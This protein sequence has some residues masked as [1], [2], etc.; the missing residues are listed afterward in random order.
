MLFKIYKKEMKDSFRDKR[1]LL[2][3]VFLPILM[4]TALTFFY[5]SLIAG[6]EDETYTL[7]VETSISSTQEMILA[8]MENV[9]LL[10]ADHPE[11]VLEEGNAHAAIY[12]ASDFDENIQAGE[13]G[14]VEIV[15]DTFSDKSATLMHLVQSRL[16]GFEQMIVIDRLQQANVDPAIT[17]AI[18]VEQR[19]MN[20]ENS[21]TM[22]LAFL[23][24]VILSIAIGVGA[25]PS[26]A[27]LFA[28]EKEKKTMEALLMTPVHRSTLLLAKYL[29]ISSVGVII[30]F[31][32]LAVVAI[33]IALF[34]E[35]IKAAV[36]FGDQT[37]QILGIGLLVTIVYSFFVAAILMITSI[38]GKTVKEAQSYSTPIMMVIIFPAMMLLGVGVNEF[39]I[40]HFL[41][42][43]VNLFTIITE[44]VFGIVDYGHLLAMIAS[45]L[46]C[47]L[48]IFIV[49]RAMFTKDEWVLD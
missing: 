47:I 38:I 34:T 42:P 3:T 39:T 33:E 6:N 19:E 45:N 16:T 1:T 8:E 49:S 24:P 7:A 28:G 10:K 20:A 4:M 21:N 26:A 46:V 43:F 44:L 18:G 35:H 29:T 2:L 37:A 30:G 23:I 31:V 14:H 32:T 15:G 36:S 5:E 11:T 22:I 40:G 12:F 17:Q 13:V 9:E 41:I 27:D 48:V 25:G